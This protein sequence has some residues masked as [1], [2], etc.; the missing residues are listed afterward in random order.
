MFTQY[1]GNYLIES[2]IISA[3]QFKEALQQIKDKRAKLGVLAIEAGYMTPA[4]VEE[5]VSMQSGSTGNLV[6]SPSSKAI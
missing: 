5:A 6:K 3:E 2:G 4:Q 1:F